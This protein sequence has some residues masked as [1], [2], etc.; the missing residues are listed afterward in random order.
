MG[1]YSVSVDCTVRGTVYE[2]NAALQ[3]EVGRFRLG[4]MGSLQKDV[5]G[6]PPRSIITFTSQV[7]INLTIVQNLQNK[8]PQRKM[9]GNGN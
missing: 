6:S 5:R 2:I 8:P 1:F 9:K 4:S 3:Q 7:S